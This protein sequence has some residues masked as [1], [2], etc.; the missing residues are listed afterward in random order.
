MI[1]LSPVGTP[2][3]ADIVIVAAPRGRILNL[4]GTV[5]HTGKRSL[6]VSDFTD[7][8]KKAL[9]QEGIEALDFF[10]IGPFV[11]KLTGVPEA[12]LPP[13]PAEQ[14]PLERPQTPSNAKVIP[15]GSTKGGVGKSTIAVNLAVHLSKL[16]RTVLVDFD[17]RYGDVALTTYLDR[18]APVTVTDWDPGR[19]LI[20]SP[21]V[22]DLCVL[23]FGS[24][25]PYRADETLGVKILADLKSR[26]DFVVVDL[27]VFADL[28]CINAAVKMADAIIL[29]AD[30]SDKCLVEMTSFIHLEANHISREKM[31]LIINKV[32]LEPIHTTGEIQRA[33]GFSAHHEVPFDQMVGQAVMR[34][35][36]PVLWP[37]KAKAGRAMRDTFGNLFGDVKEEPRRKRWILPAVAVVILGAAFVVA[38]AEKIL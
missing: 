2:E 7:R 12:K 17:A 30:Q 11:R 29:V 16:G 18:P 13:E 27:G 23:P 38:L 25:A 26:F 32:G 15:V 5:V 22:T 37:K 19:D 4:A 6:V 10:E 1:G 3:D 21:K 31:R 33:L 8:E 36:F 14:P 9:R 35:T 28:W 24:H 20:T 34:K